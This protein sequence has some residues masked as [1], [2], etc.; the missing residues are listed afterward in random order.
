MAVLVCAIRIQHQFLYVHDPIA[1]QYSR[2]ISVGVYHIYMQDLNPLH[3]CLPAHKILL[4]IAAAHR[5]PFTSQQQW[6]SKLVTLWSQMSLLQQRL[7]SSLSNEIEHTSSFRSQANNGIAG[8]F[9]GIAHQA[10]LPSLDGRDDAVSTRRYAERGASLR[11]P[12]SEY[13]WHTPC[14]RRLFP[15]LLLAHQKVSGK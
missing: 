9:V 12:R 13:F 3:N 2:C 6:E 8:A 1:F 7:T 11:D 4:I 5:I 15:T 10:L 14:N